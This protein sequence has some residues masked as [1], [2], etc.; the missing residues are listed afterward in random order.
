VTGP[1]AGARPRGPDHRPGA[2]PKGPTN[3][4]ALLKRPT[5]GRALP[6]RPTNGR[7]LPKRPTNGRALPKGL[8][9]GRALPKGVGPPGPPQGPRRSGRCHLGGLPGGA[10]DDRTA[11]GRQS[12]REGVR[13]ARVMIVEDDPDSRKLLEVW[14]SW[15]GHDVLSAASAVEAVRLLLVDGAPVADVAIL[16]IAMPEISGLQVLHHLRGNAVY[17]HLPAIF[18][19]ASDLA[20]DRAAARS[21]GAQFM[22]KPTT[23]ATLQAAVDAALI[24]IPRSPRARR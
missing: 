13:V 24:P 10:G 11:A 21:M 22:K 4:R 18:L 15:M 14:L 19:S 20:S 17:A 3:G 12:G 2:S 23:R 1:A 8:T 7:A 16:D 9:G 6:K 5:N